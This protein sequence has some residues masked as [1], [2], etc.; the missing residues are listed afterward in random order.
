[1]PARLNSMD[2]TKRLRSR[3]IR[4]LDE[5]TTAINV[6]SFRC[7]K[8]KFEWNTSVSSVLHTGTG[9]PNCSGVRRTTLN[10]V[11][12]NLALRHQR[13]EVPNQKYQNNRTVLQ[14]RCKRCGNTW[15]SCGA[16]LL[17]GHGCPKC[18][19]NQRLTMSEV[20]CRLHK[21]HPTITVCTQKY[22]GSASYATFKCMVCSTKWTATWKALLMRKQGCPTCATNK[23]RLTLSE[24]RRK[25]EKLAPTIRIQSKTYQGSMK[26]LRLACLTCGCQWKAPWDRI[27]RGHGCPK[28]SGSRKENEVIDIVERV[29]VRKFIRH[30]TPNWIQGRCRTKNRHLDGYCPKL[31]TKKFTGG[32]AIEYQ[33]EQHYNA[34]SHWGGKEKQAEVA[35]NDERKR[36]LCHTNNVF[37][38]RVPYWKKNV[39]EFIRLKLSKAGF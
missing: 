5:Y 18:A 34:I 8:C 31:T 30:A 20:I 11:R 21:T 17:R 27:S 6:H 29:T 33:G 23:R 12:S 37:L 28:C 35:R 24:I 1:M 22:A 7:M 26:K 9:C 2:V 36:L 10:D 14:C 39:E 4:L 3:G 38:I 25:L 19:G 13:I 32:V 15:H 16:S